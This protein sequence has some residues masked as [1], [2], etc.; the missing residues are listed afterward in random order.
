[1]NYMEDSITD[2]Q[3]LKCSRSVSSWKICVQDTTVFKTFMFDCNFYMK[4]NKEPKP[5]SLVELIV[6]CVKNVLQE[7]DSMDKWWSDPFR[8]RTTYD[9]LYSC[10]DGIPG[11]Q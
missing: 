11:G 3:I 8:Q 2:F 1:M 4:D 6:H 9:R 5:F 10:R 7:H